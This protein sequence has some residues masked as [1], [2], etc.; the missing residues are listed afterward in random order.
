MFLSTN[1]FTPKNT[2]TNPKPNLANDKPYCPPSTRNKH[3]NTV[4]TRSGLTY[5]PSVNPNTTTTVIHDDSEDEADKSEKEAEPIPS[6]QTKSDLSPLKAYKPK[7]SYPQRI[8]KEKVE[9]CY[10]KFID[11]IKEVRINVPLVHVLTDMP[12]YEKFL[13]DLMSNK[14]KMEKSRMPS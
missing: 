2:Q 7:I 6:K 4:F 11:L 3:V 12:N 14:S 10:V 1:W 13:K 9:E 8:R 5:D